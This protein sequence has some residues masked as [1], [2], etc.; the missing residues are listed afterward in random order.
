MK[1]FILLL[2]VFVGVINLCHVQTYHFIN[3]VVKFSGQDTI[4]LKNKFTID[5]NIELDFFDESNFKEC[6]EPILHLSSLL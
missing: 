1:K 4:G 2:V 3:E 6:W 5:F